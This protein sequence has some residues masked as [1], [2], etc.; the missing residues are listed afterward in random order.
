MDNH[1]QNRPGRSRVYRVLWPG[2]CSVCTTYIY[3]GTIIRATY[4]LHLPA[5][6]HPPKPTLLVCLRLRLEILPEELLVL[7][8]ERARVARQPHAT[9]HTHRARDRA[10]VPRARE[11]PVQALAAVRRCRCPLAYERPERRGRH[12]RRVLARAVD[13]LLERQRV[14]LGGR[15]SCDDLRNA[16]W[17]DTH[18]VG[19]HLVDVRIEHDALVLRRLQEAVP[20]VDAHEPVMHF[21]D[22]VRLA[23]IPGE[24]HVVVT[25]SIEL[26]CHDQRLGVVPCGVQWPARVASIL[27]RSALGAAKGQIGLLI[28]HAEH[29]HDVRLVL[30]H[31]HEVLDKR[32]RAVDVRLVCLPA[33]VLPPRVQFICDLCGAGRMTLLTACPAGVR[34]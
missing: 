32:R 2:C 7:R 10:V 28:Q 15:I 29:G 8:A 1:C 22:Q 14:V 30:E 25:V 5:P 20:V 34:S 16:K 21:H 23:F 11:A 18:G 6:H 4:I 19:E 31:R 27:A 33:A 3:I 13:V 26:L 12:N 9:A 24:A 17:A